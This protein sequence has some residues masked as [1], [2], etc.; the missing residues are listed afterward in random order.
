MR[1][2]ATIGILAAAAIVG[3]LS[4]QACGRGESI[5]EQVARGQGNA[6]VDQPPAEPDQF[7]LARRDLRA[8]LDELAKRYP[9]A[10]D[11]ETYVKHW[12][13][14]TNGRDA[15]VAAGK[16]LIESHEKIAEGPET[17]DWAEPSLPWLTL[18]RDSSELT[19]SEITFLR[20][21]E[22]ANSDRVVQIRKLLEFDTISFASFATDYDDHTANPFMS[23]LNVWSFLSNRAN[24]L[25]LLGREDEALECAKLTSALVHKLSGPHTLM[26]MALVL[27]FMGSATDS[28]HTVAQSAGPDIRQKIIRELARDEGALDFRRVWLGECAF[29]AD[30]ARQI[31]DKDRKEAEEFIT[32]GWPDERVA[33]D[34]LAEVAAWIRLL[35]KLHILVADKQSIV[36]HAIA[37]EIKQEAGVM[38]VGLSK[39][40][41]EN[42]FRFALQPVGAS[43]EYEMEFLRRDLMRIRLSETTDD[44]FRKAAQ[45]LIAAHAH[46]RLEWEPEKAW[47]NTASDHFMSDWPFG[48]PTPK[49][50]AFAEIPLAKQS[51]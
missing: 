37:A 30:A 40:G 38:G 19:P 14:G 45:K 17:P 9:E 13:P 4:V 43:M 41:R 50:F 10:V 33:S 48:Q 25:C 34:V 3:L 15:A 18:P 11:I 1:P 23:V 35:M 20:A 12:L 49:I 2:T 44:G 6:P 47:I 7:E 36:Q 31:L 24:V 26:E 22:G 21:Y 28:F 27:V 32:E 39:E 16:D 51:D 42:L 5:P 46:Y 29:G 8:A